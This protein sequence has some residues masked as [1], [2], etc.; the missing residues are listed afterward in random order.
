[1]ENTHST[2]KTI[3]SIAWQ[4]NQGHAKGEKKQNI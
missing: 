1:M 3:A 4:Y 2:G